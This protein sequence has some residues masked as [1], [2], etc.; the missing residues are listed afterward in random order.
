MGGTLAVSN[1]A[2]KLISAGFIAD[3]KTYCEEALKVPNHHE[4]IERAIARLSEALTEEGEKLDKLLRKARRRSDFYRQ[5]GK[6]FSQRDVS[7]FVEFWEGPECTLQAELKG[8]TFCARGEYKRPANALGLG[9]FSGMTV[10]GGERT[11]DVQY[12]GAVKGRAI[13]ADVTHRERGALPSSNSLLGGDGKT[14]VLM[15]IA[16]DRCEISVLENPQG[17]EP[18]AYTF[19]RLGVAAP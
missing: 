14:K 18:R 16:D 10:S 4:N 2:N 9:L 1:L 19:K 13:V 8:G 3:A 5:F 15:V 7:D 11:Y 12:N 6:A 17:G